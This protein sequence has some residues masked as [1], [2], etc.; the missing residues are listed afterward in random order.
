MHIGKQWGGFRDSMLFLG[1]R[2]GFRGSMLFFWASML[3]FWAS[4]LFFWGYIY[5]YIIKGSGV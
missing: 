3:F 2:V 5:I 4:M 1:G